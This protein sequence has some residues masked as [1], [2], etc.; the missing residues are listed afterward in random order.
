MSHRNDGPRGGSGGITYR[1][2]GA[3]I[4]LW[5]VT[6]GICNLLG[7]CGTVEGLGRDLGTSSRMVREWWNGGQRPAASGKRSEPEP[8]EM[9]ARI[10]EGG[11]R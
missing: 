6:A 4:V 9:D 1:Q 11:E 2:A 3:A 10:V 8:L 7:G 5:A